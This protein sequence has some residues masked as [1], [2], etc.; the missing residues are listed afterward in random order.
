MQAQG[1]HANSAQ[2]QQTPCCELTVHHCAGHAKYVMNNIT[3]PAVFGI[4]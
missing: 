3:I 4:H 2:T 1:E